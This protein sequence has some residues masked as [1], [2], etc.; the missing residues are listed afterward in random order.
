MN[1]IPDSN[2]QRLS[3]WD[4]WWASDYSWEGLTK[5]KWKGF[6][7]DPSGVI[8]V[9]KDAPEGS[10]DAN[11]QDYWRSEEL[12]LLHGD[13][14]QWTRVHCPPHWLSGSAAKVAWSEQQISELKGIINTRMISSRPVEMDSNGVKGADLRAQFAGAVL[15]DLPIFTRQSP[16]S[17]LFV[18]AVF[19]SPVTFSG[20]FLHGSCVQ[21]CLFQRNASFAGVLWKG[22]GAFR[23]NVFL[24]EVNFSRSYFAADTHCDR[25]IC[26]GRAFFSGSV[27][28]GSTFFLG[29][30]FHEQAEFEDVDFEGD[31]E[32]GFSKFHRVDFN[33]T[34][35]L[36]TTRFEG[37]KFGVYAQFQSKFEGSA[38]F[39]DAIFSG[40]AFF[41]SVKFKSVSFENAAFNGSTTFYG[42]CF[43]G[44]SDFD[45]SIFSGSAK[46]ERAEFFDTV[47][48]SNGIFR[49]ALNFKNACF[50]G[51]MKCRYRDFL[52]DAIFDGA[53]FAK[54][55]DFYGSQFHKF[56]SFQTAIWPD[57][58][59]ST[60]SSFDQTLFIGLVTFAGSGFGRLAS[61]NGAKFERG[62]V[63]DDVEES[64]SRTR[65]RKE[66][67]EAVS[68]SR[69]EFHQQ[70][71][72]IN[73]AR[74]NSGI[75][76]LN[77][78]DR[79]QL[80]N[81]LRD[82]R[83]AE[84]EGGCRTLKKH[85][86]AISDNV[87]E[88]RMY[89][90]EILAR[91]EQ[92]IVNYSEKTISYLYGLFSRF[93]DSFLRPIFGLVFLIFIFAIIYIS[94]G[95]AADEIIYK[96]LIVYIK[97]NFADSVLFSW[98][99]TFKP[100]SALSVDAPDAKN[101]SWSSTFVV[102]HGNEFHLLIVALS[103]IQSIFS[104]TLAF[105]SVLAVRRKFQIH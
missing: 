63:I 49:S 74:E 4:D 40:T 98:T 58:I 29:A 18:K 62:L 82:R 72:S 60:H 79:R 51:V 65:F 53:S 68:Y 20:T 21:F 26:F 36:G 99:N 76:F 28:K 23:S 95:V 105:L 92:H 71:E 88:Q 66:L 59:I 67:D 75:N 52:D 42:A 81:E 38:N 96:D 103:T 41:D 91:R 17:H 94:L 69:Q 31:L 70:L 86:S 45:N 44:S 47:D 39:K 5:H 85:Y 25:I 77:R 3:W 22:G 64:A 78:R 50:T 2:D 11:L 97:N 19:L 61:F 7:V 56:A 10:R 73:A 57:N 37:A 30:I 46:F 9:E 14:K 13:G 90:F 89:R 32:F 101:P 104:V 15:F 54:P 83:L 6:S 16:L 84:L 93:G 102:G 34:K 24:E 55:V 100:L 43:G 1:P 27:F 8:V 80:E 48:F 87:N 12:H 35:F 33:R